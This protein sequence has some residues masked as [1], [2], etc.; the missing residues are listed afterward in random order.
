M[1]RAFLQAMADAGVYDQ[2][3]PCDQGCGRPAEWVAK[4]GDAVICGQTD[5]T[6]DR[7]GEADKPPEAP[8]APK[9]KKATR[10]RTST[11]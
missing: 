8:K 5:C 3:P 2:A 11:R 10:K 7:T 6:V 4:G 9:A 1:Y